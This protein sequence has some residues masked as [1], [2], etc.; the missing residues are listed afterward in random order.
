M[1]VI[2]ATLT[3]AFAFSANAYS[4]KD[5]IAVTALT[6]EI[7]LMSPMA[8][9]LCVK[10]PN[11]EEGS[12]MCGVALTGTTVDVSITTTIALLKEMQEVKPDALE[13]ATN[14]FA[15]PA[16]TSVAQ[17]FIIEASSQGHELT[18]E[19]VINFINSME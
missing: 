17:N 12:V 15:S 9:T 2:L 11:S 14:G 13:Y 4:V 16:L 7:A 8:S 5:I 6:T 10:S 1:K 3:L 19:D 18:F